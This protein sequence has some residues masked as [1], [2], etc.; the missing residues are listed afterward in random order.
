MKTVSEQLDSLDR[1]YPDLPTEIRQ[2][3]TNYWGD[4]PTR[5][6]DCESFL[7]PRWKAALDNRIQ[8]AAGEMRW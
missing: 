1:L 5:D 6:N 8:P 4:N 3:A 2:A 7:R